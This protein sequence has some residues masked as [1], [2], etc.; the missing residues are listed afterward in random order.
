MTL[1]KKF[2][3]II[4]K[5]FSKIPNVY[6]LRLYDTTNGFKNISN[7]CDIIVYYDTLYMLE[8]KTI[9]GNTFNFHNIRDNQLQ[10]ML[11][12]KNRVPNI[13]AGFIIWFYDKDITVFVPI[14]YIYTLIC[15]DIK[16]IRY[17][18]SHVYKIDGAK[19]KT[20]FDYNIKD[21]LQGVICYDR[22][23]EWQ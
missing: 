14:K 10:G 12:A 1:G 18:D 23:E 21:F 19:K 2:E 7:P 20:Y 13:V 3:D 15:N 9:Q 6:C 16:S 17:D 11:D 8:L 22:E 4:R 5:Q